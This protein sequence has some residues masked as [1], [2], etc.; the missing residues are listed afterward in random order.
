[1]KVRHAVA[2]LQPHAV[3]D[4]HCDGRKVGSLEADGAGKVEF[5]CSLGYGRP[6]RLELLIQ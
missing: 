5:K 6:Q 3:Y 4:L 1:M 2:G